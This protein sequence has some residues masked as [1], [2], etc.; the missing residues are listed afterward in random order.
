MQA[1][2]FMRLLVGRFSLV[3]FFGRRMVPFL[4]GMTG[5][6]V[7]TAPRAAISRGFSGQAHGVDWWNL[8]RGR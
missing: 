5:K 7:N 2:I 6:T 1:A 3:P 8:N 4:T